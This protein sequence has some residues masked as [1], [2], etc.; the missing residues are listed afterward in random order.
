M[1]QRVYARKPV[2]FLF[3]CIYFFLRERC[4]CRY[5]LYCCF[6]LNRQWIPFEERPFV[7]SSGIPVQ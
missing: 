4:V 6:P 5:F 1:P 7:N 3:V 2:D